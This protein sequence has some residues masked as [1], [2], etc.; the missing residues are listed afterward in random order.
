MQYI[1]DDFYTGFL[2]V[3]RNIFP[4]QGKNYK[5]KTSR[6][7]LFH[8]LDLQRFK[9]LVH[10]YHGYRQKRTFKY[11]WWEYILIQPPVKG[12]LTLSVKLLMHIL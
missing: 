5:C 7:Y 11:Y 9:S 3:I 8:L 1:P 2:G 4:L 12:N 10:C 6:R